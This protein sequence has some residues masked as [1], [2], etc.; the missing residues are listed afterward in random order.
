MNDISNV[1]W[2]V[3]IEKEVTKE[4]FYKSLKQAGD[5]KGQLQQLQ[6]IN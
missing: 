6:M 4:V 5:L 1:F 2:L 3:I